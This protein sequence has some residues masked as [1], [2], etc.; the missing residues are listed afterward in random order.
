MGKG[1]PVE[2]RPFLNGLIHGGILPVT[3]K[4]EASIKNLFVA[5][6]VSCGLGDNGSKAIVWGLIV[7]DHIRELTPDLKNPD[8]NGE[9]LKQVEAE[10][11]RTLAPL[12][13]NG[14]VDPLELE[15]Y[16]RKINMNYI[17]LHKIEPRLKR[18][19]EIMSVVRERFVP[20][21]VA[22]NPHGLM[23]ALEVQDIIQLS[24]LHAQFSLL[25]TESRDIPSHYRT[26]YP[27]QDDEH[28]KNTIVTVENIAGKARYEI[29]RME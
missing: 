25:R 27:K 12:G 16:V 28:W 24:E 20:A 13:H 7:G 9:Q 18:A 19:A 3:E 4:G 26:D 6:D 5:G 15:D 29:E 1:A 22:S 10:K 17:G 21:L 11:R 23:R 2:V 8:F 14:D